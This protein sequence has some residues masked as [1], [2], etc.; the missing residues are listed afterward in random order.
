M[1]RQLPH[2]PDAESSVLAAMLNTEDGSCI[3]EAVSLGLTHESFYEPAS[4]I[5][6]ESVIRLRSNDVTIDTI[7]VLQD[8]RAS[9]DVAAVGGVG[10][11]E[12]LAGRDYSLTAFKQHVE[13]LVS[14][15]SQRKAIRHLA[16]AQEALY[17]QYV[18]A[19]DM[20]EAVALPLARVENSLHRQSNVKT[21]AQVVD[22][23]AVRLDRP[24]DK[25]GLT[26][27]VRDF[28]RYAMPIGR[29]ELVVIAARPSIGKSS[30]SRQIA[31]S[32]V[33]QGRRAVCFLLETSAADF[34][35]AVA[36]QESRVPTAAMRDAL[37]EHRK[38]YAEALRKIRGTQTLKLYDNDL[39]MPAIESRCRILKSA[40]QPD[41]VVIDY[42]QIIRG[43]NPKLSTADAIGELTGACVAIVKALG[44]P[45]V[46]MSQLNRAQE[47]DNNRQPIL[48]DLRDSGSIEA[49]AHRVIFIH[50]PNKDRFG[51]D[52]LGD[53]YR[54]IYHC[55]LIQAKNRS[56]PKCC[57]DVDFRAPLALFENAAP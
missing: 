41:I 27:G 45:V 52:Q 44:C 14:L 55:Q 2:N 9:G 43:R 33:T 11:L 21:L 53:A 5:V 50:R 7:T 56:G 1:T 10:G 38:R 28:D 31:W 29:Q 49:D 46:L 47:W 54:D 18:T 4:R 17:Q 16:E 3:D 30:L 32:A 25:D 20:H 57:V 34:V 6:A 26:T 23:V 51:A 42:L 13:L 12:E 15:A 40:F 36:A 39:T 24:A 35:E 48:S 22:E 19:D 8:L 37:P